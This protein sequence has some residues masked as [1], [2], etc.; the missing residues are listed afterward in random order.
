MNNQEIQKKNFDKHL[1]A[2]IITIIISIV[3]LF[4]VPIVTIIIVTIVPWLVI[5]DLWNI[6]K[7]WEISKK[8]YWVFAFIWIT[9][10]LA[11]LLFFGACFISISG[12]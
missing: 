3:T 10:T 9:P 8:S 2:L 1:W 5:F 12:L 4:I 7:K 6:Y 11:L